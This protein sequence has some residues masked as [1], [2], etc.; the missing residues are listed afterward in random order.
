MQYLKRYTYNGL[1]NFS[2]SARPPDL[3][4]R[5]NTVNTNSE[6]RSPDAAHV[7][8]E[9]EPHTHPRPGGGRFSASVQAGS[10]DYNQQNS[11]D[12]RRYLTPA[13]SSTISYQK[14]IRNSPSTTPCRSARARTRL[15]AAWTS[16][17]PILR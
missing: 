2:Y 6:Y 15:P 12:Q 13:F 17:C 1:L 10:N 16:R 9:L 14:Q 3:I 7:L 8:A 11:F 5:S 4:L